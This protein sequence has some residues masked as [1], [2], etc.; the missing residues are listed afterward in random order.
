MR[1]KGLQLSVGLLTLGITPAH[2]RKS[3]TSTGYVRRDLDHPRTC[4][5]K[6][7][8]CLS[9]VF[10][11]G[12]PPHMR[13]KV[14]VLQKILSQ[15]QITPA[16]A[17][18]RIFTYHDD[19]ENMDHSRT[20]GEKCQK[21]RHTHHQKGSPPHMWGKVCVT[22]SIAVEFRITPAHAGKSFD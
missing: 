20:C 14:L 2:A 6:C 16:H 9:S 10:P 12:S 15:L 7:N 22:V 3:L 5:E 21:G 11:L 18:K 1:G 8:I 13:G 4:G 17:G 19:I